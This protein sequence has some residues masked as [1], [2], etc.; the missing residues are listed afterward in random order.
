MDRIADFI[1]RY[2]T[3]ILIGLLFLILPASFFQGVLRF[4]LYFI[5]SIF[6]LAIAAR[7]AFGI[8]IDRKRREMEQGM[9]GTAY[10]TYTW[11]QR[12]GA[13][14]Q[15]RR[16]GTSHEGEVKVQQV[17]RTPDKK[18][19]GDVGDYV[20]YEDVAEDKKHD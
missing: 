6:I 4:I 14:Q 5:L 18:V 19:R 20:D 2:S 16:G 9:G 8:W 7:I 10:R 13:Q 15:Q 3:V 11:G 12:S 1:R 17:R